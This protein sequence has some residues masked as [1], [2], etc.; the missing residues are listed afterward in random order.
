MKI[1]VYSTKNYEKYYFDEVNRGQHQLLFIADKLSLETIEKAQG[2][3]GICCFV[4]DCLNQQVIM[5]LAARGIKLIALRS[6]GYDHVDMAAAK[7]HNIAVVR[8]PKYSPQSIAEFAVGL[9]LVLSRK[10]LKS[11]L[12]G[13]EY[14]FSLEELMGFNLY[15]KTVGIIGTGNIGTAFG[16]IMCGFGC[17]VLAYDPV[18]NDTCRK[19]GIGYVELEY[20]L[21]ES[22]II[23]LHCLLNKNTY[24]ILDAKE[25]S[26]MK[27][28]AMLIN[29]GRGEL[30]NTLALLHALETGQLGYAG[31]DVYEKEQ[32]LFF[33]DHRNEIIKDQQFLKLQALPNVIIT[34]HQAFLTDE[35]IANIAKTTIDN[36]TAFEQGRP[37]NQIKFLS[38]EKIF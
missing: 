29:T 22:N 17:R 10:I 24:H 23:S 18:P 21:R 11:Y 27:K 30:I 15:Q 26:Q 5:K 4:I 25:F 2:Y 13:L 9:I 28:S 32:G 31:L 36:I 3:E 35:S 33:I 14:N 16:Q 20:L 38:E 6:T 1:V 34:P 8:V 19:L 7:I 37:I 12:H